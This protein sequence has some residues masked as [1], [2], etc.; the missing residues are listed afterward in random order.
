MVDVILDGG[1]AKAQLPGNL[2]V[3]QSLFDERDDLPFSLR[4]CAAGAR[5]ARSA[6]S[7]ATWPNSKAVTRGEHTSS[8]RMA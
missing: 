1:G 5:G 4:Q 7:A 2:L 8:P 6:D 3:R